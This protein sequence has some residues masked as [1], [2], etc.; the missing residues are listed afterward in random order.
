MPEREHRHT[1]TP[2]GTRHHADGTPI[3]G[4]RA[5]P[6]GV[7]VVGDGPY[8][9]HIGVIRGAHD[10][11]TAAAEGLATLAAVFDNALHGKDR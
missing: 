5:C 1:F 4:V 6:C 11:N 8:A 9:L 7:E 10:F 2:A 3:P